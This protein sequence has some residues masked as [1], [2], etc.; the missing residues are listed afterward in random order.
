MT[1]NFGEVAMALLMYINYSWRTNAF[2]VLFFYTYFLFGYCYY[3]EPPKFYMGKHN[4]SKART[5]LSRIARK[6]GIRDYNTDFIFE[7][8]IETTHLLAS[9]SEP[10][11][12]IHHK[13][14]NF[15]DVFRF[16]V[17]RWRYLLIFLLYIINGLVFYGIAFVLPKLY[18][19]PKINMIIG[20]CAEA[21]GCFS[22]IFLVNSPLLG[23]KWS[24]LIL[25]ILSALGCFLYVFVGGAE[26]VVIAY[27]FIVIARYGISGAYAGVNIFTHEL[28]PTSIK[29]V[30]MGSFGFSSRIGSTVA[31]Y[32]AAVLTFNP[33]ILFGSSSVFGAL[34]TYFLPET[35]GKPIFDTLESAQAAYAQTQSIHDKATSD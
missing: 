16:P 27:I 13:Q 2:V 23:R 24:T 9:I 19:N 22:M 14:R 25:Y 7:E 33:L 26:H 10:G 35:R 28:F 29:A 3:V 30:A 21:A 15:K 5:Q 31:P 4:Y 11:S 17:T 8:E 32:L 1:F 12:I 34:L 18:G 20:G 6:N